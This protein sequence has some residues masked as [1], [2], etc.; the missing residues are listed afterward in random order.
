MKPKLPL[1]SAV[2]LICALAVSCAGC[3]V[4]VNADPPE[5]GAVESYRDNGRLLIEANP[6]AGY[7]FAF[8]DGDVQSAVS[9]LSLTAEQAKQELNITA[10]FEKT[11]LISA[12]HAD[13]R[14]DTVKR[15]SITIEDTYPQIDEEFSVPGL[16]EEAEKLLEAAGVEV[17]EKAGPHDAS[18]TFI[19]TAKAL[20]ASYTDEANYGV[21]GYYYSGADLTGEAVW[22]VN[23]QEPIRAPV[24]FRI[25]PPQSFSGNQYN[26]PKQAPYSDAWPHILFEGIA[27]VW[28]PEY[29]L[30]FAQD[31]VYGEKA[32]EILR[33]GKPAMIDYLA[34]T[35]SDPGH[36]RR[37]DAASALSDSP[38]A[39]AAVPALAAALSDA[40][41]TVRRYAALALSNIGPAPGSAAAIP[42]LTSLLED[43][44]PETRVN[45]GLALSVIAPAS[46]IP[47]P[48][49][50]NCLGASDALIRQRAAK[51]LSQLD[52][53]PDEVAAALIEAL[54]DKDRD[55][56][57]WAITA[58]GKLDPMPVEAIQNLL[59]IV[60]EDQYSD[61]ASA[62]QTALAELGPNDVD[63]VPLLEQAYG[64][65][66]EDG[67]YDDYRKTHISLFV[68]R[69]LGGIGPNAAAAQPTFSKALRDDN[70]DIKEEATAALIKIGLEEPWVAAILMDALSEGTPYYMHWTIVEA[71]C[72]VSAEQENALPFL[73]KAL[74]F[75]SRE[76]YAY[77]LTD[78]AIEGL[79]QMDPG[80][81]VPALKEAL[82]D[83]ELHD[84]AALALEQFDAS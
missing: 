5:A 48:A 22:E 69:V 9:P 32:N 40:D 44:S 11:G 39:Q 52:P 42:A 56:R 80:K 64:P 29:I 58:V 53:L 15:I 59:K 38:E 13:G 21:S 60:T 23:G 75:R 33:S 25:E 68:L 18:L 57:L 1:L 6:S 43:E 30:L 35:L 26:N 12:R 49:L 77:F 37:R 16:I 31:D 8:W 27:R 71:L 28:G 46:A 84:G 79:S 3:N 34:D 14:V 51:G 72:E 78:K 20:G 63:A 70:E 55:V 47:V 4:H 66:K 74:R 10:H 2:I 45:A 50:L 82:N 17:A 76:D 19:V 54:L 7:S 73:I 67:D 41:P 65:G 36:Q 83:P 81:V 62:A 61:T 24:S